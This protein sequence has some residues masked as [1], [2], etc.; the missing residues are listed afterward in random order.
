MA[1]S[2]TPARTVF[3][4]I[5]PQRVD[6]RLQGALCASINRALTFSWGTREKAIQ[7]S[8]R[9]H[10]EKIAQIA[11]LLRF[12]HAIIICTTALLKRFAKHA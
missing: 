12:A 6:W 3:F 8:A 5:V 7:L 9:L 11:L 10:I 4:I 2:E 1:A